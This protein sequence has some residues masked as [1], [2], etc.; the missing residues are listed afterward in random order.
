MNILSF[1][2]SH[3]VRPRSRAMIPSYS[4][5]RYQE[6]KWSGD[7]SLQNLEKLLDPMGCSACIGSFP[8][9]T[10]SMTH[11]CNLNVE[12]IGTWFNLQSSTTGTIHHHHQSSIIISSHLVSLFRTPMV[13]YQTIGK[14]CWASYGSKLC[15]ATLGPTP[16][17]GQRRETVW[18]F[19]VK[20][21]AAS[22][23]VSWV[24]WVS[25]C[26][27]TR[28]RM[29]LGQPTLRA[30]GGSCHSPRAGQ[31]SMTDP[32]FPVRYYWFLLMNRMVPKITMVCPPFCNQKEIPKEQVLWGGYCGLFTLVLGKKSPSGR[33]CCQT[34]EFWM[35]HHADVHIHFNNPWIPWCWDHLAMGGDYALMCERSQDPNKTICWT[36]SPKLILP[37]VTRFP[38]FWASNCSCLLDVYR[39]PF[40]WLWQ[41]APAESFFEA[42]VIESKNLSKLVFHWL[43]FCK[44]C[45]Q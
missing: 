35:L 5:S 34:L 13:L 42:R 27:S 25:S 14:L 18:F 23:W 45:V 9:S 17:I 36:K 10:W 43:F 7:V 38:T 26:F 28:L 29:F 15:N 44:L 4:W 2:G 3:S 16:D 31:M 39:F 32:M 37:L 30:L 8:C 33:W 24:S 1:V 22:S 6:K 11:G 20:P 21:A 40:R 19:R 12:P 41:E